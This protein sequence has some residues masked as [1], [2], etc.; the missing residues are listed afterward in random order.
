MVET[1]VQ[2]HKLSV[3]RACFLFG[4]LRSTFYYT[5]KRNDNEIITALQ[6]HIDKHPAHGF[7]KSTSQDLLD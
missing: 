5:S 1:A 4:L 7:P 2:Q 3:R 6:D